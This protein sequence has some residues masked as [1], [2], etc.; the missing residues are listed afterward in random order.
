MGCAGGVEDDVDDAVVSD[1][2]NTPL[3][4]VGVVGASSVIV[5]FELTGIDVVVLEAAAGVKPPVMFEDRDAVVLE[6]ATFRK[7][8][9]RV[10]VIV[11]GAAVVVLVT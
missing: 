11:T 6:A 7:L 8:L 10:A 2:W 5:V 1:C 4:F 3:E 9:V